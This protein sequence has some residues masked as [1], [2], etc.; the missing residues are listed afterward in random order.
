M[1]LF[2]VAVRLVAAGPPD[3][4]PMALFGFAAVYLAPAALAVIGHRREAGP[5]LAAAALLCGL[6]SVTSFALVTLPFLIPAALLAG[7]AARSTPWRN[8]SVLASALAAA[9]VGGAWFAA[10]IPREWRCVSSPGYSACG[11]VTTT[12]GGAIALI[13]VGVALVVAVAASRPAAA[14]R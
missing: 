3:D 11:D 14:E 7:A 6:A 10:V 13:L 12:T 5:T 9:L 4:P 2:I 8:R 1:G